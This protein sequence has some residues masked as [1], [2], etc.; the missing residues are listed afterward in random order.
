M[1]DTY[2]HF[3]HCGDCLQSVYVERPDRRS[4]SC[5]VCAACGG[6]MEWEGILNNGRIQ[7]NIDGAPC[8]TLCVDAVGKSCT[9]SCGGENHG[10]HKIVPIT[11]DNGRAIVHTLPDD[12]ARQNAEE[13]RTARGMLRA[14]ANKIMADH[15]SSNGWL[16]RPQWEAREK[17][18]LRL[19][20][21]AKLRTHK[22]RMR[23]LL[24]A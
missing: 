13:Y 21:A 12:T 4:L 14:E 8:N 24:P 5:I 7:Y 10:T 1:A 22:A 16:P 11:I 20:K 23:V 17:I 19:R 6:A 2:R 9:C 3:L 18:L 15:G